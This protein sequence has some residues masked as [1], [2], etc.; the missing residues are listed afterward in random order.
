MLHKLYGHIAFRGPQ[1]E[2]VRSWGA[3]KK[4]TVLVWRTGGGKTATFVLTATLIP[5][6]VVVLSPLLSLIDDMHRSLVA[7]GIRAFSLHSRKTADET[8]RTIDELCVQP[9]RVHVI[10]VTPEYLMRRTD[11]RQLLKHLREARGY[12]LRFVLDEAHCLDDYAEFR[13]VYR[14]LH[15]LK[16]EFPDV[17]L[18]AVT[19]TATKDD[20]ARYAEVLHMQDPVVIVADTVR[21]DIDVQVLKRQGRGFQDRAAQLIQL[22]NGSS[23]HG[24]MGIVFV[25]T[26]AAVEKLH[27]HLDNHFRGDAEERQRLQPSLPTVRRPVFQSYSKLSAE[28]KIANETQWAKSLDGIMV[29]TATMG[30]GVNVIGCAWTIHFQLPASITTLQ[31]EMGRSSRDGSGG[32]AHVLFSSADERVWAYVHSL[33]ARAKAETTTTTGEAEVRRQISES[34]EEP[35]RRLRELILALSLSSLCLR[36]VMRLGVD[37][38]VSGVESPVCPG[39]EPCSKCNPIISAS[40]S[41][42]PRTGAALPRMTDI[43]EQARLVVGV[44]CAIRQAGKSSSP[45]NV[46]D[47]ACQSA[48]AATTTAFLST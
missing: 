1:E 34:V 43:T 46:V 31:Q 9:G 25:A 17:P 21:Y 23:A 4:D 2:V 36:Q 8:K 6:V 10:L 42:A 5:G 15:L 30:M 47:V 16:D 19:G 28:M 38:V 40:H 41:L 48:K 44:V 14:Q 39:W 13:T 45:S 35:H 37:K 32:T 22:L 18:L 11:F 20:A 7:R 3:H 33:T 24:K 26:Q 29:A 12:S 27:T